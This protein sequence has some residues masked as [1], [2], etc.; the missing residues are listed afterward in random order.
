MT[1]PNI[2]ALRDE[3]QSQAAD[4]INAHA[5]TIGGKLVAANTGKMSFAVRFG[6]TLVKGKLFVTSKLAFSEK[7]S[8]EIEGGAIA[9]CDPDPEQVKIP[10]VEGN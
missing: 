4:L 3:L 9:F 7:F 1:T 8:D 6:M 2:N 10:G 5:E